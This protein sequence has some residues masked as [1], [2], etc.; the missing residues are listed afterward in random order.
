MPKSSFSCLA[1]VLNLRLLSDT[2]TT[3]VAPLVL[4]GVRVQARLA[5]TMY[6]LA[7]SFTVYRQACIVPGS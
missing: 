6:R 4:A 5:F 3:V 1:F 2:R 7:W